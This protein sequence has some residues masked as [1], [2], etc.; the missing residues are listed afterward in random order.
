MML[1]SDVYNTYSVVY[2]YNIDFKKRQRYL[3]LD[4]KNVIF[5]FSLIVCT[6]TYEMPLIVICLKS[7]ITSFINLT[8][9]SNII[10]YSAILANK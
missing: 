7:N 6:F 3:T 4:R 9:S 10:C 2:R 8:F 1:A 5:Q